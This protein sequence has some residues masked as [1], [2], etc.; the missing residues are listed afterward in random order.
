MNYEK[1]INEIIAN[2]V[3]HNGTITSKALMLELH[4]IGIEVSED[5]CSIIIEKEFN[6]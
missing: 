2:Y 4:F 3:A 5:E 6:K 1:E